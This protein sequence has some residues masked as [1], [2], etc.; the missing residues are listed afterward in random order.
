M[1][2][3]ARSGIQIQFPGGT[4]IIITPELWEYRQLWHLN[5]DLRSARASDGLMGAIAPGNWLPA[6]SDGT[7]LG[8]RPDDLTQRYQDLYEKFADSWRVTDATSLFHYAPGTSTSTFTVDS[9]PGFAV[10]RCELPKQI[11]GGAPTQP[12]QRPLPIETARQQ[13]AALVQADLRANCEADVMVTGEISFAKSYLLTEQILRN[14]PPAPPTLLFPE[15]DKIDLDSAINFTWKK[16]ADKEGDGLTYM[17]CVWPADQLHTFNQ[18]TDLPKQMGMFTG[19]SN[20]GRC[21]WLLLLLIILLV[22]L[23]VLYVRR[24]RI[25][26]LLIA[27]VVL[28]AIVLVFYFCRPRDMFRSV[29]ALQPGQAYY[30]KVVVDDGKGGT[31]ESETRRFAVKR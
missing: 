15:D 4:D 29:S 1:P 22:V 28:V 23:I 25:V 10:Q 30:W 7:F 19:L 3:A 8:P 12:P 31:V 13:C 21:G 2:T 6:L 24:R 20:L 5:I 17:H 27:I 16:T 11:E 14:A 26:L 9:W 18:C